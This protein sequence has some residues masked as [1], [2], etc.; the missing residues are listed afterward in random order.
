MPRCPTLTLV[1]LAVALCVPTMAE[2]ADPIVDF[3]TAP[4][5]EWRSINDGVMGGLSAGRLRPTEQGSA[6]FEGSVSLEN[7][8]GFASVRASLGKLDLTPFEGL[9]VRVRGDGRKYR[10]RLRT[11]D[12]F[13]GIAYQAIFDT[14]TEGWEVVRLPFLQFLPTYRGRTLRAQAINLAEI[15]QIGLMVADKQAGAFRLEVEWVRPY[16]T[17]TP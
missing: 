1:S 6:I 17:G 8:G 2:P 12:G 11:D 13:D 16:R 7:N 4:T 14:S 3:R 10:L 15:R 9:E 5:P